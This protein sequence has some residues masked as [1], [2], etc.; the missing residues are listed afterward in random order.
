MKMMLSMPRTIS[1][2]ASIK[3]AIQIFGSDRNSIARLSAN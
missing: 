2:A 1:K 3:K